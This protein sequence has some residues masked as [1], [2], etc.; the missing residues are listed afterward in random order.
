MYL[1]G[2][3]LPR[4]LLTTAV[5]LAVV[6]IALGV[7]LGSGGSKSSGSGAPAAPTTAATTAPGKPTPAGPGRGT[8]GTTTSSTLPGSTASVPTS[9]TPAASLP[10]SKRQALAVRVT[11]RSCAK[12]VCRVVHR[13]GLSVLIAGPQLRQVVRVSKQGAFALNHLPLGV[14]YLTAYAD[15]G[16]VRSREVKVRVG[17]GLA[18]A[19]LALTLGKR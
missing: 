8:T 1:A 13:S 5:L 16:K 12:G 4:W 9:S 2:Y 19:Q 7:W 10:Q 3:Y 14:Y 17:L 18:H 6:A 15:R 11:L